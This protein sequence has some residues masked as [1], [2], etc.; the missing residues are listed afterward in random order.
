MDEELEPT[1]IRGEY[2][3]DGS[4]L[5]GADI[6][7]NDMGHE[8]HFE[9]QIIGTMKDGLIE[10]AQ[11][12]LE[13]IENLPED[14]LTEDQAD[15]L[16]TIPEY[17]E[18]LENNY[19]GY[20]DASDFHILLRQI[21]DLNINDYNNFIT[22]NKQYMDGLNDP[23]KWGV[24]QGNI[25]S[26]GNNFEVWGWNDSVKK[27]LI[28]M[29]YEIE[30]SESEITPPT[31]INIYDYATNKHYDFTFEELQ[32]GES[33][34]NVIPGAATSKSNVHIPWNRSMLQ[35]DSTN[36]KTFGNWVKLRES[37]K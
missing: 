8:G 22:K 27:N 14:E 23:R 21:K 13:K 10:I 4:Y 17:I 7:T 28:D 29:I 34:A 12:E 25:I 9:Q 3:W 36:Y 30:N 35:G 2:I 1:N 19:D 5:S 15:A 6:D 37:N 16:E 20:I 26:R 18:K 32:G 33:G 31:E 24:K 11:E